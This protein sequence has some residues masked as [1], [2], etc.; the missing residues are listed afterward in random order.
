[1]K[2]N[3]GKALII[4]GILAPVICIILFVTGKL[5]PSGVGIG[6]LIKSFIAGGV[7]YFYGGRL[8][9]QA[10]IEE[11]LKWFG[12]ESSEEDKEA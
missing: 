7:C 6:L 11:A 5:V 9:K 3:I 8:V 2:E 4:V 1:M 12:K 10:R